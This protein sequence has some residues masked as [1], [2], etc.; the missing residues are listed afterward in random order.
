MLFTSLGTFEAL[1]TKGRSHITN[2]VNSHFKEFMQCPVCNAQLRIKKSEASR[3]FITERVDCNDWLTNQHFPFGW[4][5]SKV[6]LN[7]FDM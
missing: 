2:F 7:L 1:F 5:L 4:L 6:D 3:L